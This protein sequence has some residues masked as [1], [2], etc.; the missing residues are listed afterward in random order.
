[1]KTIL[2]QKI[3]ITFLFT[4]LVEF[5]NA[6]DIGKSWEF[7]E[8]GNFEGILFSKSLKDS[9]VEN[10]SLSA[11]VASVFPSISSEPFE[12]NA[13][14]FGFIQI[15]LRIPGATSG[16]IMWNN[17]SGAWGFMQFITSGDSSLQEF[18]IPVYQSNQWVGKI[19]KIMRLDFNPTVGSRIDIDY[20]RIVH[21]GALPKIENFA[22]IRTIFKQNENIPLTAII[23][24]DGDVETNLRS[25]FVLPVDAILIYGNIENEHGIIFKEISDTIDWV[26]SFPSLGKYEI[27]LKLFNDIDTAETKIIF[28]VTDKYW[29]QNEFLLSA[30]SPPYAWYG[31]PYEDNIYEDYKNAN[32]KN[33][34]W[35]RPEDE[36]I[37]KVKNHN[38]KYFLLVTNILGG[39]IYLRAPEEQI[40]PE[41]TEEMLLNLDAIIEKYKDDPNLIGYHI[42][43]EPH[44]EAFEN[45]GKVVQRIREKDPSRL[46]FVNIWPSGSGYRE[47]ID[48]L[49]QTTKLEL[50]SYDRYHF[51]NGYD[52]GEYFSNIDVIREYALKYDIPFCNIIQGI[53]TNG[54]VEEGLNWRTPSEAEHRWLV[55]SS[56]A[57]GV[58]ALIWFHW[59]GDWGL[60]G[61]PDKE[62]IYPSIQKINNEIDSLSQIMVQLKTTGVYHSKISEPKWKLPSDGI[63]K[64]VSANADLVIGYFIDKNDKN[65]F[66]LMNK[67]YEKSTIATI[68]INGVSDNLIYFDVNS[69]QWNLVSA[70]N[71]SKVITFDFEILPGSG[72]LFT[73]SNLTE[74]SENNLLHYKFELNQNYPNPFNPNTTIKYTIP[75][76]FSNENISSVQLKV[77][78][79]LG[80]EIKT[81]INQKQKPGNY[82]INFDGSKLTSGVYFYELKYASYVQT[83]KMIL[84]K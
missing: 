71:N 69:N 24:N 17:D 18:N 20:I 62:I 58:H 33:V 80:R 42:C 68:S 3:T 53:G 47:Y 76:T 43:D 35:V 36:L 72:I 27:S 40:P 67:D 81:L 10:G 60:T 8:A 22:A 5:I 11:I 12:I 45:I 55:Y 13:N 57:Y 44:E 26:I 59:H 64:S 25:H 46:S 51:Y 78:D 48:K 65:Y 23:R 16:K 84:L 21:F 73:F 79:T 74:I 83:K 34:L 66:M 30:W 32:F 2:I 61:N 1:M 6:Q 77:F 54:T 9:V 19:T 70:E 28:D 31:T 14:E 56:L 82:E 38:L 37:N 15:R 39:D 63:I 50:L 41:I 75:S 52:G 29:K 7:N 4:L 49:L